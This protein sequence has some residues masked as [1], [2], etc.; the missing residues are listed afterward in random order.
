MKCHEAM[1]CDEQYAAVISSVISVLLSR[2]SSAG[3]KA[4]CALD[5]I[6]S[7][8]VAVPIPQQYG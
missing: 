2:L 6:I 7:T 8:L 4:Q 3:E 1:D 5:K